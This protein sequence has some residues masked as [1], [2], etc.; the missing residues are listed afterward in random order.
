MNYTIVATA[1]ETNR[2]Q[3][4]DNKGEFKVDS[5]N[6]IFVTDGLT[7]SEDSPQ[8][9]INSFHESIARLSSPD[10]SFLHSFMSKL[11]KKVKPDLLKFHNK[12]NVAKGLGTTAILVSESHD[13]IVIAY[14]GNGAIWHIKGNFNSFP[15]SF[16]FPWNSFHLLNSY[17]FSKK[18]KTTQNQPASD[19]TGNEKTPSI[20]EIQKDKQYGDIILICTDGIY[21]TNQLKDKNAK[22]IWI[23]RNRIYMLKILS[24]LNHFFHS[25]KLRDSNALKGILKLYMQEL[26]P[27]LTDDA[28]IGILITSAAIKW[29]DKAKQ[30]D[31]IET[32]LNSKG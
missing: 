6:Y 7:S 22:G 4:K 31:L 16:L 25:N 28:T 2:S 18:S 24:C 5:S 13:K 3:N 11:Y 17:K 19:H 32:K 23:S 29:Q 1:S 21:S 15:D 10:I 26:K 14:S 8:T 27:F 30:E 20:I 9:V 12:R